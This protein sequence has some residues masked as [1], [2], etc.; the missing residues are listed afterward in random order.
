MTESTIYKS[1]EGEAEILKLYD[2]ALVNLGIDYED[3]YVETRFGKTHLIVC[4]K[5]EAPPLLLFHGG[6]STTPHGF[7]WFFS[8][9][10]DRYRVYAPDTIGHPGKSA[11]VRLN[12]RD[13]S[14]GKWAS[15]I[16]AELETGPLPVIGP[17]Y[18][19]GILIRLAAYA[20]EKIS[21]A[22]L[23]V[24][25]G[26][27]SGSV[28]R[29]VFEV[30]FPMLAYRRNPT[31][32]K[33]LAACKSWGPDLDDEDLALVGAVFKHLKIESTFPKM[34]TEKELKGFSAPTLVIAVRKDIF[35]P[36]EK[37]IRRARKIIPN[38]E[39]ELLLDSVHFM[40]PDQARMAVARIVE[41]LEE[42]DASIS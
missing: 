30:I 6:N 17:S 16:I 31:R 24:P 26:L 38:L 35:F 39:G 25:S 14:Y 5:T 40:P 4:G 20:P 27:V 8:R 37:V 10:L 33:L 15:D 18:G 21:R 34:A 29:M 23:V 2:E 1:K 13:S 9:L 36:A 22:V 19:G 32:E 3:K 28:F 7:K 11:Q 41:F 42:E 12:P